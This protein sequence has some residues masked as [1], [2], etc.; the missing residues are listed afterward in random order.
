M[1]SRAVS[2]PSQATARFRTRNRRCYEL[3]GLAMLRMDDPC[4]WVIVHGVV[5][6]PLLIGHAWLRRGATV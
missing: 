2:H 1:G 4:D 3:A 6:A 5:E